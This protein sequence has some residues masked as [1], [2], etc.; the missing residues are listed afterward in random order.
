MNKKLRLIII[1]SVVSVVGLLFL[2]YTWLISS[3]SIQKNQ[4]KSE[5]ADA[6]SQIKLSLLQR[7]SVNYGYNPVAIDYDNITIQNILLEQ[8]PQI[9]S[10]DIYD[11]IK[12]SLSKSNINYNFEFALIKNGFFANNSKGFKPAFLTDAYNYNLNSDGN[13]VLMLHIDLPDNFIIKRSWLMISV[14]LLFTIIIVYGLILTINTIFKQKKMSEITT[15][16]IN[17]MTHEFKTPIATIN[18]AI[19]VLKNTKIRENAEMHGYYVGMIKEENVRMHKLVQRIL[20]TAKSDRSGIDIKVNKVNMHHIISQAAESIQLI[21]EQKNGIVQLFLDAPSS[22][23]DGDEVHLTNV[24]SNLLDNAIKY[25][26]KDIPINI[27]IHTSMEKDK[28]RIDVIDNGIGMKKEAVSKVFDAFFRASTGN[29]HNVRGF[30]IGLSYVKSIVEAHHGQIKVD[31][32]FQ[33]GSRFTI[34]LPFIQES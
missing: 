4:Y 22:D 15:D 25:S 1:L 10:S 9:P 28:F 5:V 23:L 29:L 18:L 27:K 19:D 13:Y 8:M 12:R 21:L 34:L 16:F 33:K 14:S 3:I 6:L 30:G 31:S 2:Q 17:N 32:T 24:M 11:I 26:K 20:E 7:A